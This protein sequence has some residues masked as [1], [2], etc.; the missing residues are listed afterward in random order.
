[1]VFGL[2]RHLKDW[3]SWALKEAG[4]RKRKEEA[5]DYGFSQLRPRNASIG[6]RSYEAILKH[7]LTPAR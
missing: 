6:R 1:M 5:R 2:E 3:R 7:S 4:G